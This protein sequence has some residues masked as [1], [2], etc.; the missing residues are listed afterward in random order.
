MSLSG[1]QR[2]R[3]SLARALLA[4]PSILVLDDTL[5]ALDV[6][7]EA[8]VTEALRRVLLV[9]HRPGRG[10]PGVDGAAR[11]PGRPAAE[12][13]G[14]GAPSP[15]SAPTP[16][17]LATAPG[18]P[19]SAGRRRRTRRRP[20]ARLRLGARRGAQ[21]ARAPVPGA[22][23]RPRRASA[24]RV[25]SLDERLRE[26]ETDEHHRLAGPR[27]HERRRRP[28]HRRVDLAPPRGAH[29]AGRPAAALRHGGGAAD[30]RH[31]GRERRPA[32]GAAAGAARHRPR[33]P[34]DRRRWL[35]AGTDP[36]RRG[37]V[38]RRA[39]AGHQPDVLPAPFG[40]DRPGSATRAA[41][42]DLSALPA[43]RRRVPR[44]L[45]LRPGGGAVDERRRGHP[46][47]AADRVRR[48]DHRGPDAAGHVGAAD[49]ARRE[50][51]PDVPVRLPHA[52]AAGVVVPHRSRRRPTSWCARARRWSSC[53]SSRR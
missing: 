45:H 48:S 2:Q 33:H 4:A 13:R 11:R 49:R 50:A 9:G 21:P 24:A 5:S 31:R 26:E 34:A 14:P 30:D 7:T 19:L 20:G 42:Q 32:V 12:G 43:A 36:D 28:A 53:S 44:P 18:V 10:Q 22:G 51:R 23:S 47:H 25:A 38:R 37:A 46:G 35:G 3:L 40:A 6:H 16:N 41:P 52:G 15:A 8:V 27:R 1:G 29:P 39:G 17:C